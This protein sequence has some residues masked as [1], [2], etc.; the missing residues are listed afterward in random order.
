MIEF[1]TWPKI[2]RVEKRQAPI[3]TEKLDGTNAC[4]VIDEEG[5]FG[6]QSRS[7]LI[8]PEDDNHGFAA[9]AYQNKDELMKLGPGHHFGEWW[10]KGIQRGYDL[11][12]KRFS[13]FNTMRWGNHNPNTPSCVYVVPLI[14]MNSI[15]GVKEFLFGN[16]SLASPGYMRPEGAVMF[17]PDT[18][19]MFKIIIDK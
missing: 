1:K 14:S 16:G 6:C 5:N 4:V 18:K 3:F 8:T 15:V 12:E 7:R 9:W 11:N 17:D 2:L 10:G 13:L 19:T